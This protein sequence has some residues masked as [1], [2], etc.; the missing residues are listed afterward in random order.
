M[1]TRV[2]DRIGEWDQRS[3]TGG[4]RGLQRLTAREVS[5]VVRADGLELFMTRGVPIA[6]RG[7]DID[8]F[9]GASGT[10]HEAPSPAL[11][12]LAVM[13]ER[14][15]EVRD[16][17]Y[18]EQTPI[19]SVDG[20]L[21]EGGFTGYIE[22]SENVLSGDYYLVYH[23]GKSMS[24]AFVGQSGRLVDG[25]EAFETTDDE[26]GIYEVRPVDIEPV[27]LP[28]P[29]PVEPESTDSNAGTPDGRSAEGTGQQTPVPESDSA[30]GPPTD[31]ADAQDGPESEQT[32]E[33]TTETVTAATDREA[34]EPE[35]EHESTG[36]M[37]GSESTGPAAKGEP[38][39]SATEHEHMQ[40]TAES[41]SATE[42]EPTE[43]AAESESTGP[44]ESA[45][46]H[47]PAESTAESGDD[48]EPVET[49]NASTATGTDAVADAMDLELRIIP[50]VDPSRTVRHS[51]NDSAERT[52]QA[53][54]D[55]PDSPTQ[56][57]HAADEP[58]AR[59]TDD[60]T[61]ADPAAVE[62]LEEQLQELEAERDN[63]Q[64]QLEIVQQE[65]DELDE[66]LE[67]VQ[68]ERDELREQLKTV[69]Q[70]RDDLHEQLEAV[71]GAQPVRQG[72]T[73]EAGPEQELTPVNAVRK[74]AIFI[75]Y[76]TKGDVTLK[77][78]HNGNGDQE[79]LREN[80]Q[81]EVYGG[82][83]GGVTVDGH[84]YETYIE[85][86]LA[87]E[88]VN[89]VVGDLPFEIRATGNQK[90]LKGLY[91]AIPSV[92]HA[93]LQGSVDIE[94]DPEQFDVVFRDQ[95]EHP[96]LVATIDTSRDPVTG[97][98]MEQLV[99]AARRVRATG[100]SLQAAFLVTR[101][102]FGGGALTIADEAAQGR[103]LS[104][105]KRKSFVRLSRK[106]GYHLCLVEA[107]EGSPHLALP[108]L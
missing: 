86:T 56:S 92:D 60:P 24:V 28:E 1:S 40:S 49:E 96:L 45:A 70:E 13:Q 71:R 73:E 38:T 19:S 78:A 14:G 48:V 97:D 104:R 81:L 77:D 91:D 25:R 67:T 62:Q 76:K 8:G 4:Y 98:Q 12:L 39:E 51:G 79:S 34:T 54:T 18:T 6:V 42:T 102:Y 57:V 31:S 82:F 74:T 89:W 105:D 94:G 69:Q 66:Q 55:D 87:Y 47:E 36:S 106:Q 72:E 29:E 43:P 26:V 10:V 80:L 88:F 58:A 15:D 65:R 21:S 22:L 61:A 35:A 103:L 17:F 23:A 44:A 53:S 9:E 75:R 11:P 107:R 7:G 100:D 30:D 85:A 50:S 27:E 84:P 95:R 101:S 32:T 2:L 63:L 46:E 68:Q 108:E 99:T 3:F 41:E 59:T 52:G 90:G 83:D 20:T 37:A 64:E 5:G 16:R 93:D 33:P